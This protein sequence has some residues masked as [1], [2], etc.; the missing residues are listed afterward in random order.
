MRVLVDV[1]NCY[2]KIALPKLTTLLWAMTFN[3]NLVFRDIKGKEI[4]CRKKKDQKIELVYNRLSK[5]LRK[6]K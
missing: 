5:P 3:K 4:V 6:E 1:K 2:K